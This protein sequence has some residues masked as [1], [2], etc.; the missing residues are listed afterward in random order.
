MAKFKVTVEYEGTRYRGWQQQKGERTIQGCLMDVA[1]EIFRTDDFELHASVRTDAGVHALGQVF[2]LDVPDNRLTV[3]AIQ[4]KF[5]YELPHDINV[6]KVEK[7]PAIFHARHDALARSYIYQINTR[8][9]AFGKHLS[10]WTQD[11]IDVERMQEAAKK[12][13]GFK[14]F[15]SFTDDSV[16]AG[17]GQMDLLKLDVYATGPVILLHFVAK[18]YLLK[19]VRRLTGTLVAAADGRL[20]ERRI[21]GFLRDKS[22]EPAAFTAPPSGLFLHKVYYKEDGTDYTLPSNTLTHFP[23]ALIGDQETEG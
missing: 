6:L 20:D 15:S 2:H 14:D 19:M 9:A 17:S 7:M 4:K 3:Q 10:W 1:A 22:P 23:N 12:F 5:N 21:D 13:V 11:P 16:E 8:R 18:Q